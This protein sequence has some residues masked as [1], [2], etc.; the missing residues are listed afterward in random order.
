MLRPM[1][2]TPPP[3][4]TS[5]PRTS[6]LAGYLLALAAGATW[7]TTGPLST[8][9]YALLPATSIGFWR[10]LL[11]TVCLALWGLAFRRELFRVDRT[12]WVLVGL[13]GGALVARADATAVAR[14]MARPRRPHGRI[15]ARGQPVL[16]LRGEAH[17]SGARGSRR[18]DR[19]GGGH[20]TRVALVPPASVPPGLA[21]ADDG[22]RRG[23]RRVPPGSQAHLPPALRR[24]RCSDS[25]S[26]SS[27]CS[28][29][30]S[31]LRPDQ[32]CRPK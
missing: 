8:G 1:T 2:A 29:S 26:R 11:G 9:L 12:G 24:C 20:R 19:A 4:T 30:P 28:R 27:R 7:G 32:V 10:V 3:Q 5:T 16:L 13:G 17:R 15:G 21:R 25:S 31:P 22:G 23:G 6:R 14:R 18:H